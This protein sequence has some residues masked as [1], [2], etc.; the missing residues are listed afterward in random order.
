MGRFLSSFLAAILSLT[1]AAGPIPASKPP[2]AEDALEQWPE[3][4]HDVARRMLAEYGE[5]DQIDPDKLTWRGNGAWKRTV[6]LR[7]LRDKRRQVL[8]QTVDY[9]VPAERLKDILEF[10]N[11]LTVDKESGELTA[12]SDSEERNFLTLNLVDEIAR[13]KR[14]V[15]S[16]RLYY[17]KTMTLSY[18]GKGSS[19]LEGLLFKESE[20]E[21]ENDLPQ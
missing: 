2:S 1:A 20:R 10:D 17:T 7:G 14:S 18:A 12:R 8:E 21:R 11:S 5:P 9:A 15:N 3:R 19:Y 13:G 4:T 6:V 16:A